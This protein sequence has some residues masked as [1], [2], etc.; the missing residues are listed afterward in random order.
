MKP[1]NRISVD[2]EPRML[3]IEEFTALIDV[4][5]LACNMNNAACCRVLGISMNTWKKWN[6]DPEGV[7]WPWWNEVLRITILEI[8][9]SI[10]A[11]RGVTA[12]HKRNVRKA[13]NAISKDET[14]RWDLDAKVSSYGG[15]QAYLQQLLAKK[16]RKKSWLMKNA[17]MGGYSPSA[18]EKASRILHVVK[19]QK[20]YG[21]NKETVWSLPSEDMYSRDLS[22]ATRPDQLIHDEDD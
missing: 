7:T 6:K 4:L 12:K 9:G 2:Y 20:G 18:L 11:K 1:K 22:V 14:M 16:P 19:T 15:A 3:D 21:E 10:L 17:N 8:M 5:F 13:F